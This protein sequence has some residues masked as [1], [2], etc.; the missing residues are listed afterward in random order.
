MAG[1]LLAKP[2]S[3]PTNW[4]L[5]WPSLS[6]PLSPAGWFGPAS[7][8]IGQTQS[9][10]SF[11]ISWLPNWS[12][13]PTNGQIE[14]SHRFGK[15]SVDLWNYDRTGQWH[16]EQDAPPDTYLPRDSLKWWSPH[17]SFWN[18]FHHHDVTFQISPWAL[19][20]TTNCV[21][22]LPSKPL[23]KSPTI[24]WHTPL[25]LHMELIKIPW[26]TRSLAV[27]GWS[28]PCWPLR[29][30]LSLP[31]P[32][33]IYWTHPIPRSPL[34]LKK[35]KNGHLHLQLGQCH[36]YGHSSQLCHLPIHGQTCQ[37]CHHSQ[38]KLT[39]SPMP[40][41]PPI[42]SQCCLYWNRWPN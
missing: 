22:C 16:L 28:F 8:T 36:L 3:S 20:K 24:L 39:L 29:R 34:W 31:F 17:L 5:I 32:R 26:R 1:K 35:V 13:S 12:S 27:H 2:L 18:R 41:P 25:Q 30:H 10:Q 14:C 6:P 7:P 23:P 40:S 42:N 9:P 15:A 11:S 21:I 4:W 19:P 33:M 38:T 37:P